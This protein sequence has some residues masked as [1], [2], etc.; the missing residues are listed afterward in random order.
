VKTIATYP[1]FEYRASELKRY[2]E[3]VGLFSIL[4]NNGE[5]VH[6]KPECSTDFRK[7]L[8]RNNITDVKNSED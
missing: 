2:I 6:Y 5:I 1:E 4:L 7:W 8:S 3:D